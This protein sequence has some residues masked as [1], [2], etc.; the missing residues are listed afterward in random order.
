MVNIYYLTKG[1]KDKPFL[2]KQNIEEKGKQRMWLL[3]ESELHAHFIPT[4]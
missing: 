4:Y 1:K 3:Y 2:Q